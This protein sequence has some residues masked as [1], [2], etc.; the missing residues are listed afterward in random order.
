MSRAYKKLWNCPGLVLPQ[1]VSVLL[2]LQQSIEIMFVT[3]YISCAYDAYYID[4]SYL[5]GI[6]Q[7][8]TIWLVG[9]CI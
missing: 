1:R 8:D 2:Q 4:Q 7:A 9:L 6:K 5:T 3:K